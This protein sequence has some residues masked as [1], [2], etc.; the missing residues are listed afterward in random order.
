LKA[1]LFVTYHFPP[2]V[3]GIQ[4]RI[5]RYV[6]ELSRRGLRVRV[7]VCG[8]NVEGRETLAGAEILRRPGGLGHLPRNVLLV[9]KNTLRLRADVVHVF[10]GSSTILG[11]C[12]LA[13]AR[14]LGARPVMSLFGREDFAL[15]GLGR[16]LLLVSMSLSWSIAVNS[17]ATQGMLPANFR[18]K[19]RVLMGGANVPASTNHPPSPDVFRVLYVGRLVRRKGVDDLVRA[20]A[21]LKASVPQMRLTVVGDGPEKQ[22]LQDLVLQLNLSGSAEFRGT[23]TGAELDTEYEKCSVLVL[24]SKDVSSDTANEGLGLALIEA[25][26]HGK[27]LIGTSHGGIPEIVE[28]GE[29]GLLVPPGDPKALSLALREIFTNPEMARN[30]GEAALSRA[31]ARF[32]WEKAT[33]ALLESY[34]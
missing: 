23:L 4:T 2:E 31:K 16:A 28:D 14:L 33:D 3:G 9:A 27:P 32:S 7:V 6:V 24:P 12:T 15:S 17:S 10:T 34:S 5:S 19:A 22:N 18:N 8:R 21:T 1:V 29:N 20:V 26:M 30:M 13:S 11:A 25:S